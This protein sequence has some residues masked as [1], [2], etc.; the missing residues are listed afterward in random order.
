MVDLPHDFRD[1][2]LRARIE[3]WALWVGWAAEMY[4]TAGYW[5]ESHLTDAQDTGPLYRL[6]DGPDALRISPRCLLHIWRLSLCHKTTTSG[7]DPAALLQLLRDG[8][9]SG[10]ASRDHAAEADRSFSVA[11][12]YLS[13]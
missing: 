11:G 13:T 9:G 10:R 7:H 5:R 3:I 4:L 1:W 8:V 12:K 6:S 2:H